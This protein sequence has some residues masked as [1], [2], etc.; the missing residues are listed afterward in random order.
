MCQSCVAAL[1][2]S[3]QKSIKAGLTKGKKDLRPTKS[4]ALPKLPKNKEVLNLSTKQGSKV[5]KVAKETAGSH[6]TAAKAREERER[7]TMQLLAPL[8]TVEW[9]NQTRPG[10]NGK[11]GKQTRMNA[12]TGEG[13]GHIYSKSK[14]QCGQL[15][16]IHPVGYVAGYMYSTLVMW[17]TLT[18]SI[19]TSTVV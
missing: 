10:A 19:V 1:P 16:T 15:K 11:K 18:L 4:W 8:Y 7:E 17:S 6:Q 12:A 2:P 13:V 5:N 9:N 3:G 14:P